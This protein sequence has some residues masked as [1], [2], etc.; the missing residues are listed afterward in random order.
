LP[1]T[2]FA[3]SDVLRRHTQLHK[4]KDDV[5]IV[6][7]GKRARIEYPSPP[8]DESAHSPA[9]EATPTDDDAVGVE[10]LRTLSQGGGSRLG[11]DPSRLHRP[12]PLSTNSPSTS[13]APQFESINTSAPSPSVNALGL[14]KVSVSFA[15]QP[16][17][18]SFDCYEPFTPASIN[19]FLTDPLGSGSRAVSPTPPQ[20]SASA[21]LSSAFWQSSLLDFSSL[22]RDSAPGPHFVGP[23]SR[24]HSPA[25]F[26]RLSMD[27]R[28]KNTWPTRPFR[29][30]E[31]SL[32]SPTSSTVSATSS[33]LGSSFGSLGPG[34]SSAGT[35]VSGSLNGSS[36][37]PRPT[38]ELDY[39]TAVRMWKHL[40]GG[41]I[42]FGRPMPSI[43]LLNDMIERYFEHWHPYWPFLHPPT[44]LPSQ[45]SAL[46]LLNMAALG[47]LYMA[48]T[49]DAAPLAH[50]ISRKMHE[51]LT[52]SMSPALHQ[53]LDG[54]DRDALQLCQ[55]CMLRQLFGLVAGVSFDFF[56]RDGKR[57][58]LTPVVGAR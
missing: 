38:R 41:A 56:L 1:L 40:E 15:P 47:G 44:F 4:D 5:A 30:Q 31:G 11:I 36:A 55:A 35:T 2:I 28:V 18:G 7:R 14:D 37:P 24:P 25:S 3:T 22:L 58:R 39:T 43:A 20:T 13:A 57:P 45:T 34:A 27:E 17:T 10:L 54:L 49:P 46:V 42:P 32:R 33:P 48:H 23:V 21:S 12:S 29:R 8:A 52:F 50:A 26:S 53:P 19:P 6:P 16:P 9:D 51:V